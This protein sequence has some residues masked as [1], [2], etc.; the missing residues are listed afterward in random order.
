MTASSSRSTGSRCPTRSSCGASASGSRTRRSAGS[1]RR[2]TSSLAADY[3]DYSRAKDEMFVHTDV[4]ESPWFVVEADDKRARA[5]EL[6]LALPEPDPV[7]GSHAGA[8]RASGSPVRGRLP[9]ARARDAEVRARSRRRSGLT[10][11][12]HVIG[13]GR[14]VLARVLADERVPRRRERDRDAG[15]DPRR[16]AR[17]GDRRSRPSSTCSA[18]CSSARRSPTRS[19]ASSPCRPR[20]AWRSSARACWARPSGTSLTWWRGLPVELRPRARRRPRR[21][22]AWSTAGLD[23]R[24]LGRARRLAA[25]RRAS[26]S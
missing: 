13:A 18:R 1:C 23:A 22:G 5:A 3:I 6:H 2:W 4:R 8:G 25:G 12:P 7:R 11:W 21:R 14:G 19:R 26:A 16:T 17:S 24:Q 20:A 10:S 15:R 9:P